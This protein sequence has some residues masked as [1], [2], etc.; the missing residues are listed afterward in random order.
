MGDEEGPAWLGTAAAADYL[1]I[2]PRTLYR[3]INEGRLPAYR[4]ARVFRVRRSDLDAFLEANRIQPGE[5]DHLCGPDWGS[6]P[7]PVDDE[8]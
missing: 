6:T 5:L 2:R 3:L 7:E 4:P 1:G 8:D